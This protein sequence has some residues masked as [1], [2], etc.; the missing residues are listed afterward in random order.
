[1]CADLNSC[2]EAAI[3]A[4]K[5]VYK[6]KFAARNRYTEMRSRFQYKKIRPS[7][8][9]HEVSREG[10]NTQVDVKE[11]GFINT[12]LRLANYAPWCVAFS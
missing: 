9:D 6:T 2:F 11:K 4:N 3:Y 10:E 5:D 8:R 1:M 12:R 7:P